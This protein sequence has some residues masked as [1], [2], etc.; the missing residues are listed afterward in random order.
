[1]QHTNTLARVAVPWRAQVRALEGSPCAAA[2]MPSA[3]AVHLTHVNGHDVS[4]HSVP[5][6]AEKSPEKGPC[7][8]TCQV[9]WPCMGRAGALSRLAPSFHC[10]IDASVTP[11]CLRSEMGDQCAPARGRVRHLRVHVLLG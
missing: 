7:S 4:P 11:A 6:L 1:V 8:Y 10:F 2:G 3:Q 5:S 9:R